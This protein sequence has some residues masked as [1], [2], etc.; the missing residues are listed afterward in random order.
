MKNKIITIVIT[1]LVTAL[2][3]AA[4]TCVTLSLTKSEPLTDWIK[5][6]KMR[7]HG[8]SSPEV[9]L[10]EAKR[11]RGEMHAGS[12][13]EP[14]SIMIR[15]GKRSVASV[16]KKIFAPNG[17]RYAETSKQI[18]VLVSDTSDGINSYEF[19]LMKI[20][21]D[22]DARKQIKELIIKTNA[23]SNAFGLSN[24]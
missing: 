3:T 5:M 22:K 13:R 8:C 17:Q 15:E 7:M 23:Q 16:S 20:M 21:C 11:I 2:V 6:A 19:D 10:E 1:A 24:N 12:K 14:V 18:F 9:C 4:A